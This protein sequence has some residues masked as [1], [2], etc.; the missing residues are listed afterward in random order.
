MRPEPPLGGGGVF[1]LGFPDKVPGDEAH[2]DS[3]D[4]ESDEEK[5]DFHNLSLV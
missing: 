4:A 3:G 1:R 5:M 2:R